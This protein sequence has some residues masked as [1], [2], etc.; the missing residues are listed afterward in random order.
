MPLKVSMYTINT[1]ETLNE[2]M[3]E[4]DFFYSD[5]YDPSTDSFTFNTEKE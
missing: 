5:F 2:Y 3:D 1:E 4:I